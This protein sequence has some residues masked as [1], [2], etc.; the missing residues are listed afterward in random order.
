MSEKNTTTTFFNKFVSLQ[1]SI[2]VPKG[3]F[4]SFGKYKYRSC[5]DILGALRLAMGDYGLFV[6]ITDSIE[7]IGERYYVKATVTITDG[8]DFV[9]GSAYARESLDKKGMDDSQITGSTSSYARK[10]ALSGLL[11]LDDENDADTADNTNNKKPPVVDSSRFNRPNEN[12]S[13]YVVP[14]GKFKDKKLSELN[15]DE[16]SSY[17]KWIVENSDKEI[18]GKM[19]EFI[20]KSREYLRGLKVMA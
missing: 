9:Q 4:N 2:C 19:K 11:G 6:N 1:K 12:L 16:I 20:D 13:S 14:I 7:L 3:N 17:C 8:V 18:N 15:P 10:Y 5:E